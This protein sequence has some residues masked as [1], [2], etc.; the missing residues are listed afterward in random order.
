MICIIRLANQ[1]I[2]RENI[3]NLFFTPK[4]LRE[5]TDKLGYSLLSYT[6]GQEIIERQNLQAYTEKKA[7]TVF[8]GNSRIIL[9]QDN[10]SFSEKVFVI[11]HEIGHI[12]LEHTYFGILG[13]SED[14]AQSDAQ[15][16]EAD[17]F[18]YQVMA[19]LSF[20][21]RRGVSDTEQIKELTM[22]SGDRAAHV[23]A[24]LH[25]STIR[26]S[27]DAL[28]ARRISRAMPRV[29]KRCSAAIIFAVILA[30]PA[31]YGII[32]FVG[33]FAGADE[34]LPTQ[35]N[36]PDL[37]DSVQSVSVTETYYV[38]AQGEK[39]HRAGCRYL[40]NS[41]PIPVTGDELQY[42]APCKIC[43]PNGG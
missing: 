31:L 3:T 39:Y 10:L 23:L 5:L 15:E 25:D 4:T 37:P 11:L 27:N 21:R 41:T 26:D 29:K 42:Y 9:Y 34:A 7:F 32:S 19:P 38:T 40:K 16:Q 17:A 36:S 43:F 2:L 18:A 35:I 13:K 20:L 12:E 6:E 1:F 30:L 14:S 33:T 28:V 22:L 8:V 24:L